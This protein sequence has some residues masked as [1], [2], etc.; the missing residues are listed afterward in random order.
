M[1]FHEFIFVSRKPSYNTYKTLNVTHNSPRKHLLIVEDSPS[2]FHKF[3]EKLQVDALL[4]FFVLHEFDTRSMDGSLL[5][6]GKTG[7]NNLQCWSHS[8]EYTS[9][10]LTILGTS[11][12]GVKPAGTTTSLII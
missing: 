6:T 7:L 1:F 10:F 12:C 2:E 9:R 5:T 4:D 11:P 3:R 8:I